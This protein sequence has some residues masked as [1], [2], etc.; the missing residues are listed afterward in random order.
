M[1]GVDTYCRRRRRRGGGGCWRH[2][3][4]EPYAA[5]HPGNEGRRGAAQVRL[6]GLARRS[7]DCAAQV[8][9]AS[10]LIAATRALAPTSPPLR[11]LHDRE[12][13]FG[14]FWGFLAF[15]LFMQ[16]Y[17][18]QIEYQL[19]VQD[20]YDIESGAKRTSTQSAKVSYSFKHA[21]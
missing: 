9:A 7:G 17:L 19:N 8:R 15:M 13:K 3:E 2:Q 20:A 5:Q 4:A 21:R 14:A 11:R 18:K 10:K 16:I 12:K 6:S 1:E